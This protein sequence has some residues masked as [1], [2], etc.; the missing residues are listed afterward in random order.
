MG[1][2]LGGAW[3]GVPAR[4]WQCRCSC[5]AACLRCWAG[6][7]DVLVVVSVGTAQLGGVLAPALLCSAD[8][9]SSNGGES[10]PLHLYSPSPLSSSLGLEFSGVASGHMIPSPQ[11]DLRW[12]SS[13]ACSL[14]AAP[15]QPPPGRECGNCIPPRFPHHCT[16]CCCFAGES[17]MASAL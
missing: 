9:S 8:T 7:Y 14:S 16:S 3:E 1:R 2:G 11:V 17:T 13:L 12:G 6:S 4:E 5:R 15:A 10:P